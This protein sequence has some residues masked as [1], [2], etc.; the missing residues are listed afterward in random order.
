MP[1]P[2]TSPSPSPSPSTYLALC[3]RYADLVCAQVTVG[4]DEEVDYEVQLGLG[5]AAANLTADEVQEIRYAV[6]DN[7]RTLRCKIA[8]DDFACWTPLSPVKVVRVSPAS[9]R[10]RRML[11]DPQHPVDNIL[12]LANVS[13]TQDFV[14]SSD[15]CPSELWALDQFPNPQRH[16]LQLR[17][18]TNAIGSD[19]AGLISNDGSTHLSG[20]RVE[21]EVFVDPSLSNATQEKLKPTVLSNGLQNALNVTVSIGAPRVALPPSPPPRPLPPP[22]SPSPSSPLP[23][24]SPS[25]PSLPP[26]SPLPPA[27]PPPVTPPAAPSGLS[28]TATVSVDIDT[29]ASTI[30]SACELA[31]AAEE[32]SFQTLAA[33]VGSRRVRSLRR[34][35][36]LAKFEEGRDKRGRAVET[37]LKITFECKLVVRVRL[38]IDA[39]GRQWTF[40]DLTDEYKLEIKKAVEKLFNVKVNSVKTVK[41]KGKVKR[42][43]Y[44][45]AKRPDFKKAVVRLAQGHEIDFAAAE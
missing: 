45:F 4:V 13:I 2:E 23:P 8:V 10:R 29:L 11:H 35:R 21:S 7:A 31:S 22:P 42:N 30:G 41:V 18:M 9:T 19:A 43:R 1:A 24:S 33:A 3:R 37:R 38:G 14:F 5:V 26:S 40:S 16:Y 20:I 6:E 44:G 25:P 32:D 34:A 39:S 28:V 15:S 17:Q 36:S 27:P 12:L